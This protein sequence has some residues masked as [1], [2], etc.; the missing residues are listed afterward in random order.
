MT[1]TFPA[2]TPQYPDLAGKVA[3]VTGGSKGIGGATVRALA[4]N[5]ARVAVTGR[6][7]AALDAIVGEVSDAGAEAIAVAADVCHAE[8]IET[9]RERVE[10]ELGQV[11]ILIPFAGGFSAYT[12][13]QDTSEEDWRS[14]IDSNLT[15]TF[16]CL[17]A[18]LPAMIE[19]RGGAIVTM[20]SNAAR[21]LDTTL[22]ASY[23]AAKAGIVQL[24]RHTAREVGEHGI[25]VNCVAPGT[26]HTERVDRI[27]PREV[28]DD[29]VTKTPLGRLGQPEESANAT[30]FLASNAA[31]G[32]LTGVTIDISGGRVM[33]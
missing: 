5:G 32:Y 10:A 12:A 33:L 20:A 26:T 21:H 8:Q 18:F 29:L 24:T 2:V 16:L 17:K 27:L 15:S 25:R 13:V 7:T 14:V 22:T 3:L 23:A 6:H 30:L 28:H 11:E 31:S 1:E 9:M 19:R 4:A